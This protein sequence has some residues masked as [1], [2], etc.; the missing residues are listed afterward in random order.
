M[1]KTLESF[2]DPANIPAKY[3]GQLD[4]HFGDMPVLDPAYKDVLTFESGNT[5]FPH[6]PMYWIHGKDG[7]E[8]EA[9]AVGTVDEMERKEKVCTVKKLLGEDEDPVGGEIAMNGHAKGP[10]TLGE[11]LRTVPTAAPSVATTEAE[12]N[13]NVSVTAPVEP[14]K[15][16]GLTPVAVQEGQLVSTS[17]PEP[18]SFVTATEGLDTLS[19]N[20]KTGN[21]PNGTAHLPTAEKAVS[22][23]NTPTPVAPAEKI[24]S[25][26]TAVNDKKSEKSS[27]MQSLERMKKVEKDVDK[28]KEKI[29][30]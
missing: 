14:A 25:S 3:G 5:D 20:E 19:L 6:G 29:G 2:I 12:T 13:P 24:Q 11:G 9:L 23:N 18:V 26:G 15:A 1:K 27:V 30:V 7:K 17:R 4:F 28:A 10:D 21:V 8:M 16:E 22:A